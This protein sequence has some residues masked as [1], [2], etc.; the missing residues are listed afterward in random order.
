MTIDLLYQSAG[1]VPP[2]TRAALQRAGAV[3]AFGLTKAFWGSGRSVGFT[4]GAS[5]GEAFFEYGQRLDMGLP[6][7]PWTAI[8]P[9]FTGT[10]YIDAENDNDPD[11]HHHDWRFTRWPDFTPEL[12]A[13]AHLDLLT[14]IAWTRS[15]RPYAQLGLFQFC[16]WDQSPGMW[17]MLQSLH[18]TVDVLEVGSYHLW[19]AGAPDLERDAAIIDGRKEVAH[20]LRRRGDQ[21]VRIWTWNR[22]Q[23]GGIMTQTNYEA[24]MQ[25]VVNGGPAVDGC[26]LFAAGGMSPAYVGVARQVC[27]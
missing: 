18:D 15:L 13:A 2:T 20:D 12:A 26:Y 7:K 21:D 22:Y 17:T 6:N 9:D 8:P 4:H 14:I 10:L 19:R 25:R 16:D 23:G 27:G 24:Y 1:P 5:A 11:N 3:E